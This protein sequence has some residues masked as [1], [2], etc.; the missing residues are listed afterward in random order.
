VRRALQTSKRRIT[1]RTPKLRRALQAPKRP[2]PLLALLVATMVLVSIA[3]VSASVRPPA[4]EAVVTP[5][6]IAPPV[7]ATPTSLADAPV[8]KASATAGAIEL[9]WTDVG[10]AEQYGVELADNKSLADPYTVKVPGLATTIKGKP[11]GTYYA[12]ARAENGAGGAASEWSAVVSVKVPES[13]LVVASFNIKC[14]GCGNPSWASRRAAV[15]STIN[16][17][18]PDVIGL[19][20]TRLKQNQYQQ[21]IAGLGSDY[22]GLRPPARSAEIAIAYNTKVLTLVE[23]GSE[24]L[25]T[26]HDDRRVLWAVLKQKATGKVFL[27]GVTHLQT[28]HGAKWN[29]WRVKEAARATVV[30][31]SVAARHGDCP[32]IV[33]GDMNSY[34][35]IGNGG[36]TTFTKTYLDPLGKYSD[37]GVAKVENTVGL[38]YSTWNGWGRVARKSST[39]MDYIFVTPMRVLE[40]ETVVKV[41][42]SG[43]FIGAIPSD[44]NMVRATVELP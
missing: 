11:A 10:S 23:Q 34:P 32:T 27:F 37:P 19:Q 1:L 30:L 44:H 12:R 31:K 16:S 15:I 4:P 14:A 5:A 43:R 38:A 39:Y 40:W 17:Q 25:P 29:S 9:A 42:S 28:G 18:R 33:V 36:Y 2:W 6:A 3:V 24:A 8:V 41:D 26:K 21:V 20:E 35:K 7:L 22:R 13:P